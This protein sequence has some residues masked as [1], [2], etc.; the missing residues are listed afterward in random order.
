MS[1]HIKIKVTD[2]VQTIRMNRPDKKNA[3]T[4]EMYQKMADALAAADTDDTI[5]ASVILG[6]E[7]AFCAG[8]DLK[9]FLAFATKGEFGTEVVNF[10]MQLERHTKPLLAGVDGLAIGVGT[11]M[12]MHC[13]L[14][15]ASDK[16]L[17][18][19]PF[20]DLGLVPEAGS[21]LLG[22]RIMGHQRAFAMLA[23]GEDFSAEDAKDAGLIYRVTSSEALEDAVIAAAKKIADK[24]R[25]A[26]ALSRKLLR[27]TDAELK[28]RIEEETKLFAERLG[29]DEAKAAFMAFMMKKAG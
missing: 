10:L 3:L 9:D 6:V 16:S 20:T 27:D 26:M 29:T 11:T 8:N 4:R 17:L 22:P 23:M 14:A 24:P 2:G 25:Q 13:D 18:R 7:G 15:F 12:L 1:E 21:S 5:G 19:T 28:T